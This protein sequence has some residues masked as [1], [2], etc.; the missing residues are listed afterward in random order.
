MSYIFVDRPVGDYRNYCQICG[1]WYTYSHV[2]NTSGYYAICGVCGQSYFGPNGHVCPGVP[3]PAGDF[4]FPIPQPIDIHPPTITPTVPCEPLTFKL[5]ADKKPY[6]CPVC[7]G[8]A[9]VSRPPGVAGDL[10][11]W[12]STT[13]GPYKCKA[14]ENG[15]IWK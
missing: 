2:C 12:T 13:H 4:P 7:D 5:I 6:K 3:Q 15:V 14:C 8:T 11:T 10:D 1:Q 9:L